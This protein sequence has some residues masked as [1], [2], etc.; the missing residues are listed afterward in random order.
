MTSF[1]NYRVTNLIMHLPK[2][3]PRFKDMEIS[4]RTTH[5]LVV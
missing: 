2:V 4:I 1:H 3:E 5:N